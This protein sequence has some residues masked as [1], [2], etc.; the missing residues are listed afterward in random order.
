MGLIDPS[1]LISV[2][3]LISYPSGK[4]QMNSLSRFMSQKIR[5]ITVYMHQQAVTG[6]EYSGF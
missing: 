5:F 3:A 1:P 4:G 6:W 2:L